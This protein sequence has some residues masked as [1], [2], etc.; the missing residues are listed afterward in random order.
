M[1]KIQWE[2]YFEYSYGFKLKSIH[3]SRAAAR[4]HKKTIM[5]GPSASTIV[6]AEL[7]KVTILP[8]LSEL[9]NEGVHTYK[10]VR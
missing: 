9:V 6:K 1:S 10:K 7:Y 5:E 4:L 2:V 8:G 3:N